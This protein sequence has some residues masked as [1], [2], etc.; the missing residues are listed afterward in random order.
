MDAKHTRATHRKCTTV[1]AGDGGCLKGGCDQPVCVYCGQ[2]WP[3]EA[4]SALE[5][6]HHNEI[7]HWRHHNCALDRLSAITD[8]HV[9]LRDSPEC[10]ECGKPWP[11]PTVRASMGKKVTR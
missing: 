3:C 5:D 2:T 4:I 8:L 10:A 11:C 7:C 9:L 6:A 1:P